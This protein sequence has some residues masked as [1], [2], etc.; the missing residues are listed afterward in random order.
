M[1]SQ[2]RTFTAKQVCAALGVPRGTLNAW[3]FGGYFELFEA[4][5]TSQGKAREF[6]L[7]DVS[8]LAL[9]RHLANLGISKERIK[10]ILGWWIDYNNHNIG[11]PKM[12]ILCHADGN[13]S[14]VPFDYPLHGEVIELIINTWQIFGDIC[15]RLM[16]GWGRGGVPQNV[17]QT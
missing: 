7:S 14:I 5:H 8:K 3:A 10:R 9:I 11:E 13:F 4:G 2:E 6:T 15:E 1:T 16:P 17:P 12:R